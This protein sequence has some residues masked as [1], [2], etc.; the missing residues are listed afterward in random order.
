[1]RIDGCGAGEYFIRWMA[2][3]EIASRMRYL[4]LSLAVAADQ[5][6]TELGAVGG[7]GGLIAIDAAGNV[8]L[9]FNCSGMYRGV[10]GVD[11]IMRTGIYRDPLA[12]TP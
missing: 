1:M 4:G 2:A 8:A 10:V 6:V 12:A 11:G 3:H 7:S 5:V 9:P